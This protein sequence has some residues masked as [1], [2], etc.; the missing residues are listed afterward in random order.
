MQSVQLDQLLV[1][2]ETL[3]L[4]AATFAHNCRTR[5]VLRLSHCVSSMIFYVLTIWGAGHGSVWKLRSNG[6][7][8]ESMAKRAWNCT[9]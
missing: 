7:A 3:R 6:A 4:F 1:E 2:G 5:I 9:N 8:G